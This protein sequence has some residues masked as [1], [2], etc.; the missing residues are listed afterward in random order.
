MK[1]LILDLKHGELKNSGE[2]EALFHKLHALRINDDLWDRIRGS[3]NE[4][5]Q[6]HER[7]KLLLFLIR[8]ENRNDGNR[9]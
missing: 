4:T 1:L 3:G 2:E 6:M 8:L 5:G 7:V 9:E